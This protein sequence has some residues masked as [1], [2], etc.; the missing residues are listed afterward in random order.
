MFN[1]DVIC[2]MHGMICMVWYLNGSSD[3]SY[4]IKWV[5]LKTFW[6]GDWWGVMLYSIGN[7]EAGVV[8]SVFCFFSYR[9]LLNRRHEICD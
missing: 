4:L 5:F 8:Y 9:F 2:G 6:F 1:K 3:I 7:G